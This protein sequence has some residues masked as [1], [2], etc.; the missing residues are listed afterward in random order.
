MRVKQMVLA[1]SIY[2]YGLIVRIFSTQIAK[3]VVQAKPKLPAVITVVFVVPL[4]Q[5]LELLV[6]TWKAFL[7]APDLSIASIKELAAMTYNSE[8]EAASKQLCDYHSLMSKVHQAEV[9]NA[10]SAF[11]LLLKA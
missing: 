4:I 2:H 7:E 8:S 11:S 3:E 9:V 1:C 5:A 10:T 6:N